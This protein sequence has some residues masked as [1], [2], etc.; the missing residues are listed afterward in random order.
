MLY[1]FHF[2]CLILSAAVTEEQ[3]GQTDSDTRALSVLAG[4]ISSGCQLV[5]VLHS[6][7]AADPEVSAI[8]RLGFIAAVLDKDLN[9]NREKKKKTINRTA[10]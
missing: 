7:K 9:L 10:R 5:L 6:Y 1:E 8:L 2:F 4:L 3:H